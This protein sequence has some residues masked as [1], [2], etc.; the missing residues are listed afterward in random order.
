MVASQGRKVWAEVRQ[1]EGMKCGM[2][3]AL[4]L[5]THQGA[6][7]LLVGYEDGTVALWDCHRPQTPLAMQRLHSEPVMGLCLTSDGSGAIHNYLYP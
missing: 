6:L 7:H 1:G 3:M 2:C 5:C 4:H